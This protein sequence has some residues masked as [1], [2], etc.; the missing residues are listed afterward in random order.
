VG[1]IKSLVLRAIDNS[2]NSGSSSSG[3]GGS[4]FQ[5]GKAYDIEMDEYDRSNFNGARV[6][7]GDVSTSGL[8][9]GGG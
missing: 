4:W 7:Y 3:S 1:N 5:S 6:T 8:P 2:N 9:G